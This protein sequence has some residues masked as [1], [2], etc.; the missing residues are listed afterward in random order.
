MAYFGV[1]R[2]TLKSLK[3]R[4][5]DFEKLCSRN[6]AR[7]SYQG[8][9]RVE[10][11]DRNTG[12]VRNFSSIS[13][14]NDKKFAS[15]TIGAKSIGK[16]RVEYVTLDIFISDENTN[17]LIPL[18]QEETRDKH[19]QILEHINNWYGIELTDKE[20]EYK[21]LEMNKTVE[22]EFSSREYQAFMETAQFTAPKRYDKNLDGKNV[23]IYR[24]SFDGE[25]NFVAYR[26]DS[27]RLKIYNKTRHLEQKRGVIVGKVYFRIEACLSTAKKIKSVFGTTKVAEITDEMMEEYFNK[28]VKKDVFDRI[29]LY[30]KES[31]KAIEVRKEELKEANAKTWTKDLFG[32]C[33]EKI[34]FENKTM[35]MVYDLEQIVECIR[36]EM[37]KKSNFER[38]IKRCETVIKGKWH[39]KNNLERYAEIKNKILN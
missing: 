4:S 33:G 12:E 14:T 21:Y 17:N 31:D 9:I 26:N 25:L 3:V 13:I 30:L 5:I 39:K 10:L 15:L 29:E 19:R 27:M 36:K 32:I 2:H 18:T 6:N 38:T 8:D 37:P 28:I 1:D 11:V 20:A 7:I 22:L 34:I 16:G 35:E 23:E 24:D